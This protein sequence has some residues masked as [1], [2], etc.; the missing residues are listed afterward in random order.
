MTSNLAVERTV[1]PVTSTLD[2]TVTGSGTMDEKSL[3]AD[4]ARD[5]G[6]TWVA[7]VLTLTYLALMTVGSGFLLM[8]LVVDYLSLDH[9][10][11]NMRLKVKLLLISVAGGA[12]GSS[13]SASV[14]AS[15]RFA[16]GWETNRGVKWPS[17]L[18]KDKFVPR[19][20]PQFIFRPILGAATAVMLVLGLVGGY[21]IAIQLEKL[22]WPLFRPEG[23]AFLSAVV[24][25]FA[26][27]FIDRVRAMF[28]ALFG[29][30][31]KRR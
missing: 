12:F 30:T 15:Q 31:S 10:A 16:D 24:G 2:V 14:S 8:A 1:D 25:L 28:D 11:E 3:P 4:A 27:T 13:I 17:D 26:K 9:F 7:V 21:L 29:K 5:L 6:R 19:Q 22:D 18:P 20:V 23:L